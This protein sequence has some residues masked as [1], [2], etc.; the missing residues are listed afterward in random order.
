MTA[1]LF[2]FD[3]RISAEQLVRLKKKGKNFFLKEKPPTSVVVVILE[4][5]CEIII[6]ICCT[7]PIESLHPAHGI[8]KYSWILLLVA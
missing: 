7:R 4:E 8:S 3:R 2:V 1:A 5:N 6:Y